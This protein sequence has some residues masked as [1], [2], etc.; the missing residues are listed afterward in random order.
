MNKISILSAASSAV[1]TVALSFALIACGDDSSSTGPEPMTGGE[2]SSSEMVL[3][4]ETAL[5]SGGDNPAS[6]G[7]AA[8]I[9]SGGD[10]GISSSATAPE[11]S[12]AEPESSSAAEPASSATVPES[13][14]GL[15]PES[16]SSVM[17][18]DPSRQIIK[19]AEAACTARNVKDPL[20]D[21]ATEGNDTALPP[22]AHIY[23]GTDSAEIVIEEVYMTCA[24]VIEQIEVSLT[25]EGNET[26][27]VNPVIDM[28]L[29]QADCICPTRLTFKIAAVPEFVNASLLE[30]SSGERMKIIKSHTVGN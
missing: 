3:S 13:S 19:K 6:S 14:S 23:V 24:A 27:Y 4:S 9:S 15:A 28:S 11:S 17:P 5:S 16:S 12:A 18:V 8:S 29:P 22:I 7:G 25:D 30:L 20:L 2:S 21:G 1:V 10:V 26:L